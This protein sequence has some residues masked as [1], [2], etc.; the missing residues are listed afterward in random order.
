MRAMPPLAC[1]VWLASCAAPARDAPTVP[2][3]GLPLSVQGPSLSLRAA[4]RELTPRSVNLVIDLVARMTIADV[5]VDVSSNDPR[6]HIRPAGCVLRL[7]TPPVVVHGKR[8]PYPLPDVPLCSV[9]LSAPGHASYPLLLRVRDASGA[10]LMK[11][12]ATAVAIQGGT[13]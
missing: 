8:P 3:P 1:A 2:V 11:P 4:V 12:I 9:V 5:S 6:L 10:D 13:S 7:L